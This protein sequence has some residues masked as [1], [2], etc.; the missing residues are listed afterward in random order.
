MDPQAPT[1]PDELLK[2]LKLDAPPTEEEIKSL[3][4]SEWLDPSDTL[5]RDWLSRYQL[6]DLDRI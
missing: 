4:E 1:S 2:L 5:P 3:I 6:C